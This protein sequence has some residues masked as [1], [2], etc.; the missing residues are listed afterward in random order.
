[1]MPREVLD[2][3]I[4]SGKG[5]SKRSIKQEKAIN[6]S[7]RVKSETPLMLADGDM[8]FLHD[9]KPGTSVHCPHHE[10]RHASAF[11]VPFVELGAA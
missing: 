6:S 2:D 10:D 7:R 11:I 9:L 5:T 1:M 4:E 3:L 8:A